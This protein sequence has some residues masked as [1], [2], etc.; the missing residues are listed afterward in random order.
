MVCSELVVIKH[1]EHD[2]IKFTLVFIIQKTNIYQDIAVKNI[3]LWNVVTCFG[4][5]L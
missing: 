3:N 4:H 5:L 1:T 2:N